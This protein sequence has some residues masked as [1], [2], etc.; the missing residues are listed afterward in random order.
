MRPL[1]VLLVLGAGGW[2]LGLWLE[3]PGGAK[4]VSAWATA[5]SQR[6][7]P[8][9]EVSVKQLDLAWPLTVQGREVRW[10]RIG[11]DPILEMESLVLDPKLSQWVRGRLHWSAQAD[12]IRLDLTGLDQLLAKGK[13]K[14]QGDLTG[15]M[16]L[17]GNRSKVE[18]MNLQLETQ[19]PG[20]FLSNEVISRLLNLM[21][22][23]STRS[24]LL[25]A[26]GQKERFHFDVGELQVNA[27]GSD[28]LL[29]FLL[30]GDHLLEF[31]LRVPKEALQ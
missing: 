12:G 14:A 7:A 13:W 30:D 26:I 4:A 24:S 27:Q 11:K 16:R 9:T 31:T 3:S 20:G 17:E 6:Q 5:Q 23:D 1:L 25:Q 28:Y 8:G 10:G 18:G 15:W 22:A 21:P 29:R 19:P 2:G